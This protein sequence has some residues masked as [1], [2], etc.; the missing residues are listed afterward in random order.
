VN[1]SGGS[2]AG[3]RHLVMTA[4]FLHAPGLWILY[5][6]RLARQLAL[7]NAIAVALTL[8]T[9][10][11]AGSAFGLPGVVAAWALG[12]VAWGAFLAATIRRDDESLKS[13]PGTVINNPR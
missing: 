10:G 8:A 13:K 11:A 6:M 12:H 7:R 2:S 9:M 4:F 1:P 5:R 3:R